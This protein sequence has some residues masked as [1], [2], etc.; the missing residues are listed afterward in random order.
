VKNQT[1][2][3]NKNSRAGEVKQRPV[4]RA[5]RATAV[6]TLNMGVAAEERLD[7]AVETSAALLEAVTVLLSRLPSEAEP[8]DL[9][10]AT[11]EGLRTLAFKQSQE[12][13]EAF[14]RYSVAA[15]GH[16]EEGR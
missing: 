15:K 11:M 6:Q 4:A 1:Q 7:E 14:D 5:K 13:R 12:L 9:R 2:A 16:A 3:E 8:L 10:V